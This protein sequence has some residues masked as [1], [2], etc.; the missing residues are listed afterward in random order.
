M[1]PTVTVSFQREL[2]TLLE[3]GNDLIKLNCNG[4]NQGCISS[5]SRPVILELLVSVDLPE[6]PDDEEEPLL[7]GL[8]FLP[9]GRLVA[10]DNKNKK[11]IIL[12]ERLQRVGTPYK[13]KTNPRDVLY[14]PHNELAVT[15]GGNNV[16]FLSVISDNVTRLKREINT[17]FDAYYICC[18]SPS[19]MV[20]STFND[21]RPVRMITVDCVESEFDQV[22]F[23]KNTYKK[24][25][26]SCTYVQSKNTLVLTDR[27]AHTVFIYDTFKG[28]SRAVTGETIKEP[29]GACVGPGETVLVCSKKKNSIVHLTVD[30]AILGTYPVDMELPYS[31]CVS[32]DGT[33]LAVSNVFVGNR[34]LQLYKISPAHS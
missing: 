27:L 23:P 18:K 29:R 26:S 10:V 4:N 30:G 31:I 28:T 32:K 3:I 8:D 15:R 9:D 34:K 5:Q 14:L 24:G 12:N 21:S 7:S 25:E 22:K 33:R 17:P 1:S 19:N 20:V 13:F 16:S 2:S 11:M 6:T